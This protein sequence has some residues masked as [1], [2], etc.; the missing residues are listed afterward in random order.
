MLTGYRF[1]EDHVLGAEDDGKAISRQEFRSIEADPAWQFERAGGRLD[2]MPPPGRPHRRCAFVFRLHVNEYWTAN[3]GRVAD[4]E[5]ERWSQIADG[6]DRQHDFSV[7]LMNSPLRAASNVFTDPERV[8]DIVFEYVSPGRRARERDYQ[9]KREEYHLLGVREYVIVDPRRR[10]VTVLNWEADEYREAAVLG[11]DHAY[12]T[13]LLPGL[14]V[15]LA[16]AIGHA[17][18]LDLD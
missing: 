6:G 2:V 18:P 10:R 16:A 12:T 1:A 9:A 8:P 15:P 4:V 13:P 3:R 5:G 11:P 7:V 17:E 14:S